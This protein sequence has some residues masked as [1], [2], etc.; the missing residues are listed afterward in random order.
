MAMPLE[1]VMAREFP[2]SRS[3]VSIESCLSFDICKDS[4][5]MWVTVDLDIDKQLLELLE[6]LVDNRF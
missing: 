6:N 2:L 5:R 3:L 4:V 1:I